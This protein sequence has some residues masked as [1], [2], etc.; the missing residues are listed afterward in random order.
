[1]LVATN[2]YNI[3]AVRVR[4]HS[5]KTNLPSN[6]AMRAAGVLQPL[7]ICES[8]VQRVAEELNLINRRQGGGQ[9]GDVI[10]DHFIN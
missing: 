10:Y 8:M 5:C 6:T 1:M 3:P 7:F 2:A 4:G 9:H